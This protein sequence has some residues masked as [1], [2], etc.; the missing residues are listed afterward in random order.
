MQAPFQ[1]PVLIGRVLGV[2]LSARGVHLQVVM[3]HHQVVLSHFA[4]ATQEG[5]GVARLR[6]AQAGEKVCLGTADV[7]VAGVMARQGLVGGCTRMMP[8]VMPFMGH[9]GADVAVSLVCAVRAICVRAVHT[10]SIH[11]RGDVVG[12]LPL[13]S[14]SPSSGPVAAEVVA[15]SPGAA[16]QAAVQVDAGPVALRV[17]MQ[18][19]RR[20]WRLFLHQLLAVQGSAAWRHRCHTSRMIMR[21]R[22]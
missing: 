18:Q 12:I 15:L 8:L 17:G 5:A 10:P 16:L 21:S 13:A 14:R 7:P 1:D 2:G 19:H 6:L 11:T 4:T 22:G 9:V 20:R 3:R